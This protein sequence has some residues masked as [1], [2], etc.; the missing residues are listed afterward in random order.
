MLVCKGR[1]MH[2][3]MRACV[4]AYLCVYVCVC[5]CPRADFCSLALSLCA[6][7]CAHVCLPFCAC[8]CFVRYFACACVSLSVRA[9]FCFAF[10]IVVSRGCLPTRPRTG[11]ILQTLSVLFRSAIV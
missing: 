11:L 8:G 2:A 6:R 9:W 10:L 7:V 3:C 5:V 4:R 1:C